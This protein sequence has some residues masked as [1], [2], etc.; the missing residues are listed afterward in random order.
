MRKRGAMLWRIQ[1]G[2]A[3]SQDGALHALRNAA[4]ITRRAMFSHAHPFAAAPLHRDDYNKE[5]PTLPMQ[6]LHVLLNEP[7][8]GD[9]GWAPAEMRQVVHSTT[10][11]M[12]RVPVRSNPLPASPDRPPPDLMSCRSHTRTPDPSACRLEPPVLHIVSGQR[13]RHGCHTAFST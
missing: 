10:S 12:Q 1:S 13:A 8:S 11:A 2:P 9:L 4:P 3:T 7:V 6:L 5:P